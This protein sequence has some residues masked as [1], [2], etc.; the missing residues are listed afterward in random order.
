VPYERIEFMAFALS[1]QEPLPT[2]QPRIPVTMRLATE[3]DLPRL[4]RITLPSEYRRFARRL[5]HGRLCFLAFLETDPE[6][7]VSY[8][9]ATTEIAPDIDE[10]IL[11]L[12]SGNAYVDEAY[13][14]PA[15]RRHGIQTAVHLF[16]LQY[17]Q[18][19]GCKR[20]ILIV[21]VKNRASLA[22]VRKL[23]YR[24][25]GQ[26]LFLRVMRTVVTPLTVV[27]SEECLPDPK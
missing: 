17:L 13:T 25:V 5:A 1:L 2:V 7:L 24:K 15:Y 8:C 6:E 4:R 10:L 14:V 27:L 21:D 12:P 11:D 23:G 3:A 18:T 22:L 16:R 19:L 9:W 26:A 20:V